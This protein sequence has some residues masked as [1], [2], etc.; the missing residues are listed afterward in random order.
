[1]TVARLRDEMSNAEFYEWWGFLNWEA[2]E[3]QK[4]VNRRGR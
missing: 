4:E 1:M 3:R 2:R